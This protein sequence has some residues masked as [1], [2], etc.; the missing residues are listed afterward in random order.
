MKK[1]TLLLIIL[2]LL[3]VS[4]AQAEEILLKDG[5]KLS[6]TIT[7]V[8][9]D[10]FQIK[11]AYGD[12]QV[13]KTEIVSISFPENAPKEAAAEVPVIEQSMN[14]RRYVN[15]TEGFEITAPDGWVM[16][17][18]MVSHDIHGALKSED[19]TLFFMYTPEKFAG[20]LS[21]YVT[22]AESDFQSRFKDF[23]KLSQSEVTL[24]GKKAMRLLW[25]GKNKAVRDTPIKALVYCIPSEGKMIRLS[26]LTVEPLFDENL[27]AFEKMAATYHAGG[28]K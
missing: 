18:E 11:T 14:G 27:L 3:A 12:I 22:L 25:H 20:T 15:K 8:T 7:G 6:G 9:A 23:E 26:F 19:E 1:G 4:F 17:P 21:T 2:V 10:K 5:T 28:T 16:A 13:P 24:D